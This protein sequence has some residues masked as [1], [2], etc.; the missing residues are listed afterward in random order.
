[1]KITGLDKLQRTLKQAAKAAREADGDIGT[2]KFDPYDPASIEQAIA[3]MEVMI[4]AKFSGAD[5]N[6][7]IQ[8]MAA[9]MKEQYR[10]GI[11]KRAAAERL[12]GG[13]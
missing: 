9:A 4:D 7:L 6:P 3:A 12:K 10:A 5:D 13:K 8:E 2:V 11:L 1:M